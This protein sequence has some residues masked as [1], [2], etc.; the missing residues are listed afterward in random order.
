MEEVKEAVTKESSGTEPISADC[1]HC[2]VKIRCSSCQGQLCV[3]IG[4]EGT[5]CFQSNVR[6]VHSGDHLVNV[7]L[8]CALRLKRDPIK[9]GPADDEAM[10][11]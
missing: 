9:L 8:S 11:G 7:C 2:R 6:I 3:W 1:Q 5:C 10:F 4:E